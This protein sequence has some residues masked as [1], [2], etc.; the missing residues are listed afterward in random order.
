MIFWGGEN[1]HQI[2]VEMIFELLHGGEQKTQ[3]Q[4]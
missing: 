4:N 3:G 2:E 1:L